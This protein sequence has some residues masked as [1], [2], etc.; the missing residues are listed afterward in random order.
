MKTRIE[1]IHIPARI[2]I[3][4]LYVCE[5]CDA[6]WD[7]EQN[8]NKCPV[9]GKDVCQTCGVVVDVYEHYIND[10]NSYWYNTK[11]AHCFDV[12]KTIYIHKNCYKKIYKNIKSY[13]KNYEKTIKETIKKLDK[14]TEE[15]FKAGT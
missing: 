5:N 10:G 7:S 9:C 1:E 11:T 8:I 6:E 4:E 15:L 14:L 12:S 3:N 13:K 2:K